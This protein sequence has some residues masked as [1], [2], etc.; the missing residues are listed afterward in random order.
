MQN[1]EQ[2]IHFV[3]RRIIEQKGQPAPTIEN[4]QRLTADLGLESLDV[5]KVVAVLEVELEVDPFAQLVAITDVRTVGDLAEAYRRALAGETAATAE[6]ALDA[7]R[8]RAAARRGAPAAQDAQ[9][10]G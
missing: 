8:Q 2:L 10:E 3:V 4:H 5:A 9:S 1:P 6:P 7:S